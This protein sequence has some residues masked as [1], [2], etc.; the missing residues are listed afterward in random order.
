[1]HR[2]RLGA[3]ANCEVLVEQGDLF[4]CILN[5]SEDKAID[6]IVLSAQAHQGFHLHLTANLPEKL[7]HRAPCHVF[8]VHNDNERA[9]PEAETVRVWP[10]TRTLAYGA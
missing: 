7:V 9:L 2:L 5:V 3:A 4:S 10:R 6:V 8:V 1:M